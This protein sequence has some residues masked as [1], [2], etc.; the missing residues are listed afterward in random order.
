M[1]PVV[2][3]HHQRTIDKINLLVRL[4]LANPQFNATQIAELLGIGIVRYSILK[5]SPTYRAIHN[6]YM[7]GVLNKLDTKVDSTLKNTQDTLSFA[8]PLAMEALLKQA[9]QTKDL[10]VQNKACNDILDRDGH[11]AKVTRVGLATGEQ[12]GV[13]AANERD[14]KTAAE[15]LKALSSTPKPTIDSPPQTDTTQ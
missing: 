6:Q 12:G 15:L 8:V 10:R 2:K 9:L 11:F 13:G 7:T 14:N 3:K 5:N 1:P 4:E